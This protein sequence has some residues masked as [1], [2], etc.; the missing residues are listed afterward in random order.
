[1]SLKG[2]I[3][4]LGPTFK[5]QPSEFMATFESSKIIRS[6]LVFLAMRF[7]QKGF[8]GDSMM[9]ANGVQMSIHSF[10]F[11]GFILS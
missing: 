9:L 2:S 8:F 4:L 1:L 6:F 5:E 7:E 11:L 10:M 3:G